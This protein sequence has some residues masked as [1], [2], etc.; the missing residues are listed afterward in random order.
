M[1]RFADCIGLAVF[2]FVLLSPSAGYGIDVWNSATVNPPYNA[3]SADAYYEY[4]GEYY[5]NFKHRNAQVF[6]DTGEPRQFV[7]TGMI[8]ALLNVI[9]GDLRV[10]SNA[11]SEHQYFVPQKT[12]NHAVELDFDLKGFLAVWVPR[13]ADVWGR[14]A[15]STEI[16]VELVVEHHLYLWPTVVHSQEIYRVHHLTE[17]TGS[18]MWSYNVDVSNPQ[19]TSAPFEL[20]QGIPYHVGVRVYAAN[21]LWGWGDGKAYAIAAFQDTTGIVF[22]HAHPLG[23]IDAHVRVNSITVRLDPLDTSPPVTTASDTGNDVICTPP[24]TVYLNATDGAGYG[25]AGTYWYTGSDPT[26]REYQNVWGMHPWFG[27]DDRL[28]FYSIDRLGQVEDVRMIDYEFA[29]IDPPELQSPEDGFTNTYLPSLM[30]WNGPRFASNHRLQIDDSPDF[31]DPVYD[32][33]TSATF[34]FN[35]SLPVPRRYYWRTSGWYGGACAHWSP[36]SQVWSFIAGADS[37]LDVRC[38]GNMHFPPFSQVERIDLNGF[39][40]VNAS[41]ESVHVN[42]GCTSEGPATLVDNG[43]PGSLTGVTPLLSPG[44]SYSPPAAALMVPVIRDYAV[45]TVRYYAAAAGHPDLADSCVTTI[46]FDPPVPTVISGFE[47]RAM[48]A[49]V[50]LSWSVESDDGI[51][52]YRVLR[53]ETGDSPFSVVSGPMIPAGTGTYV[54]RTAAPGREY[55]YRLDVLTAGGAVIESA[56]VTVRTAIAELVLCQNTPNPFNPATTIAFVLPE[57]VHARLSVY[58]VQGRLVATLVDRPLDSGFQQ[59]DW[60]AT[61]L[62]GARVSSGVYFYRLEAG[63]ETLTK[64]MVLLQ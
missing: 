12:G 24:L 39:T 30:F 58:D 37:P 3:C 52:G 38:P 33:E 59:V 21:H 63:R 13:A 48:N 27:F 6:C 19:W 2:L 62:N 42:Y 57:A 60:G 36:W 41:G 7:Y 5:S 54:D 8:T 20:V 64:K 61:D 4:L 22:G 10:Y 16:K 40:I 26:L 35:V 28:Y 51:D 17:Y 29:P 18:D 1:R 25:V 47:A 46:V 31:S 53:R 15:A 49:G 14:Q 55:K 43:N 9:P 11:F 45:Q 23:N 44:E 32:V 56:P 34:V 50:E